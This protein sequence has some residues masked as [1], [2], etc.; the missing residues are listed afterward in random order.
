M[1][2]L[3]E[4]RNSFNTPDRR[5]LHTGHILPGAI[6]EPDFNIVFA[7]DTSGSLTAELTGRITK[8]LNNI[9]HTLNPSSVTII[10][11]D[12]RVRGKQEYSLDAGATSWDTDIEI[13]P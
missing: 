1:S 4:T 2:E 9:I 7:W 10:Y 3:I 12:T 5:L 8:H 13:K 6:R 11:C